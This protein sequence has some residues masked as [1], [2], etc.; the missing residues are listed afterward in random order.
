MLQRKWIVRLTLAAGAAAL[1]VI[2]PSL[3]TQS[4]GPGADLSGKL[5]LG[6]GVGGGP[7]I[8]GVA[9]SF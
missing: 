1:V 8:V 6:G 9:T 3:L 2:L 7:F 5:G 4:I